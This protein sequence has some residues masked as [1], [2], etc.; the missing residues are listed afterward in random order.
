MGPAN[1]YGRRVTLRPAPAVL[2]A[3]LL[4]L[5]VLS[6]AYPLAGVLIVAVSSPDGFTLTHFAVFFQLRSVSLEL[7]ERPLGPL[8]PQ[9][10]SPF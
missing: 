4:A 10:R 8:V 2:F 5:L 9:R 7:T 1:G 3:D 6:I